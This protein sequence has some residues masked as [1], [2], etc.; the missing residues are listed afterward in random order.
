LKR[1]HMDIFIVHY[2]LYGVFDKINNP[3]V[4]TM[5][6]KKV[7]FKPYNLAVKK[8]KPEVVFCSHMEEHSSKKAM[9][10]SSLIV[11][12]GSA[13]LGK[14]ALLDF[15]EKNKKVGKIRFFR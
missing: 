15:D 10:Y 9:Y 11:N 14:F 13:L 12:P 4:K 6:G 2:P 3:I 8:F 1:K 5:H 7:G